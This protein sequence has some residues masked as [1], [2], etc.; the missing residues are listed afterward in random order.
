VDRVGAP[1]SAGGELEDG[2]APVTTIPR[3]SV[4]GLGEKLEGVLDA[5][6]TERSVSW[7]ANW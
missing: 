2:D 5:S 3:V 4:L 7:D 1:P 6:I